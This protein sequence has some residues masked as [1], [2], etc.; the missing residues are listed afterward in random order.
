MSLL[1][2]KM[3]LPREGEGNR[4]ECNSERSL[5][6]RQTYAMEY[7]ESRRILQSYSIVEGSVPFFA[8]CY[9]IDLPSLPRRRT[10]HRQWSRF[11]LHRASRSHTHDRIDSKMSV[12]QK[13]LVTGQ[14]TSLCSR[15]SQSTFMSGRRSFR[16]LI[17]SFR[18]KI[19]WRSKRERQTLSNQKR[20]NTALYC[21]HHT[22]HQKK[23]S[24][25]LFL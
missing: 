15:T 13:K 17:H 6:K 19:S 4:I 7:E 20:T 25:L 9:D 23:A 16:R 12:R 2:L 11:S 3:S 22:Q 8:S 21:W 5:L 10:G 18:Q 1:P 24:L 14:V